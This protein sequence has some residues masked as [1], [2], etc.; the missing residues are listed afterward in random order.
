MQ[1]YGNG[2][3]VIIANLSATYVDEIADVVIAGD[4][5]DIIPAIAAEVFI[6]A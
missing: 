4:V 6:N 2:A 1:A 5:S 3:R